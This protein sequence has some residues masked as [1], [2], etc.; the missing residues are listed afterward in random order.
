MSGTMMNMGPTTSTTLVSLCAHVIVMFG[1]V[2]GDG[3][4]RQTTTGSLRGLYITE[5]NARAEAYLGVP[6]AQPPIGLLRFE[7][8]SLV[9]CSCVERDQTAAVVHTIL[10]RR[11]SRRSAHG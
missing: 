11:R 10:V 4:V 6:Y 8:C 9:C 1:G 5:S 2:D 3:P 7:V